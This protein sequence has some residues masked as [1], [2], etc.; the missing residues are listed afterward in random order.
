M[1]LRS[2]WCVAAY[3]HEIGREPL[4]RMILGEPVVL[5]RKEDGAPVA[6]E[7]RCAHRHLPLS[8]GRLVGDIL[9]CRADQQ[10]YA[11]ASRMRCRPQLL[12]LGH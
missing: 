2:F 5:F 11:E 1:F 7:D 3:D 9:Q 8:M 12:Q 4:G 10:S 6:F